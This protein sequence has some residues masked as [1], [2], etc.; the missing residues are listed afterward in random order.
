MADHDRT[1]TINLYSA[2]KALRDLKTLLDRGSVLFVS[3]AL[4]QLADRYEQMADEQDQ[5]VQHG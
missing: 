2:T 5:S 4:G 3:D 1:V